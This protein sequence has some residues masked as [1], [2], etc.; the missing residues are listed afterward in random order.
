MKTKAQER[1]SLISK[2]LNTIKEPLIKE[3]YSAIVDI[4]FE[5]DDLR[6]KLYKS[7]KKGAN[8]LFV[9]YINLSR[10]ILDLYK[11]LPQNTEKQQNELK[12]SLEEAM[13]ILFGDK[14]KKN[15]NETKQ[16]NH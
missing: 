5:S 2:Q 9:S 4:I 8:N 14:K 6:K 1:K 3:K 11:E 13:N 16:K 10:L 15:D 12:T 7:I